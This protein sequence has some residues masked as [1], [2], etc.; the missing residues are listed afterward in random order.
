MNEAMKSADLKLRNDGSLEDFQR[1]V[2]K[3][4]A[5]LEARSVLEKGSP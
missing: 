1:N 3:L 4:L 2:E 5:V